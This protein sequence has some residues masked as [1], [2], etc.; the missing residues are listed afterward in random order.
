MLGYKF[1]LTHVIL[2]RLSREE[3]TLVVLE[4]KYMVAKWRHC[5]V[6]VTSSNHVTSRIEKFLGTFFKHK[7]RYGP[8]VAQLEVVLS[9]DYL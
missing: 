9:S 5:Y 4:V 8:T 2:P 7:M 3:C 1:H 6:K